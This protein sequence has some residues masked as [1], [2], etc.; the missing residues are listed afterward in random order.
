MISVPP[1]APSTNGDGGS[2][3]DAEIVR[4]V[5][6]GRRDDYGLLV[7]RYHEQLFRF[8]LGMVGDADA[9]TDLVQDSLVK[10]YTT[11]DACRDPSRF[12]AWVYQIL[13]NRCRDFLKNLRRAHETLDDHPGLVSRIGG[14]AEELEKGEL[15]RA[16]GNAVEQL[17]AAHREAFLLKHLE[18]Y[19]YPEISEMLG[20]SV[21][22]VK[23]R[24]HR[25]RETLRSHLEGRVDTR[26]DVTFAASGS[27]SR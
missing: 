21:S 4:R 22:A 10:A 23:M 6:E 14:P 11:L 2:P 26:G 19:T 12:G 24:V 8:A 25:S 5:L 20:A 27:S 18:G 9:A 1:N 3:P 17:P 15:R 16:L 7:R 13:R